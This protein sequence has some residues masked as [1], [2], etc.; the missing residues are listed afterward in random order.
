M[1]MM[2]IGIAGGTG[3]RKNNTLTDRLKE[4]FGTT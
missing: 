3:Q 4:Y 2:V 1:D